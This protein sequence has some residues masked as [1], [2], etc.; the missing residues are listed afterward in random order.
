[1]T[2]DFKISSS[3]FNSFVSGE[4]V[5]VSRKYKLATTD[6]WS[7][8]L[9]FASNI[10]PPIE[11]NGGSG[12]RRLTLFEFTRCV[13]NVDTELMKRCINELPIFLIEA[14]RLYEK[15]RKTVGNRS[16]WQAGVLPEQCHRLKKEYLISSSPVI[17]F[18][19][20]DT[21]FE[22]RPDCWETLSDLRSMYRD[23][24]STKASN[25]SKGSGKA[26]TP[27]GKTDG[28]PAGPIESNVLVSMTLTRK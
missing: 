4:N 9:L 23:F 21:V 11:S 27:L 13:K 17:A 6:E 22:M 24:V 25:H 8:H 15:M 3:T 12:S 28:L 2:A 18:I 1:L 10:H 19:T 20:D 14:S 26:R 5:V 16:L 7:A